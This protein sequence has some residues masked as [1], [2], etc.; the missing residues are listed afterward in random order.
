MREDYPWR[1]IERSD[2]RYPLRLRDYDRMPDK[3]YVIGKLPGDEPTVAIVGARNC[4]FYGRRQAKLFGE[5]LAEK[6]ITIISGMA[7][8]IDACAQEGALSAGGK[9]FGVLGCGV[10]VCYPAENRW[11]YEALAGQGG[12]I[13]EFEPGSVPLSW[14]FP[15]RNRIISGLADIVLVIEARCR[16]GSL[17]TVEYA[18]E[19]GKSVFALPGR[20]GDPLSDGCN[21]LIAEGA[22]IACSPDSILEEMDHLR[23]RQGKSPVRDENKIKKEKRNRRASGSSNGGLPDETEQG[24]TPKALGMLEALSDDPVSLDEL[25]LKTGMDSSSAVEAIAELVFEGKVREPYPHWYIKG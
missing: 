15:I 16:S 18:L 7:R 19:Q 3:L 17:I 1:E 23:L 2:P 25:M 14:H 11:L 5:K 9:S 24:L 12:I 6:G 8:G 4:S 21:R 20:A 22:G 10:D 13:S